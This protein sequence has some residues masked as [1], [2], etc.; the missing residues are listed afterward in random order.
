MKHIL[1]ASQQRLLERF[2]WSRVLIGL[3]FDGTLAPIVRIPDAAA[4]P[5][6]TRSVLEQLA[7]LYPTVVIS[8]RARQ[9]VAARL[10]GLRL[11]EIV[12]NHGLE[13]AARTR[14]K[15]RLVV[16]RWVHRLHRDLDAC[17]GV[18]IEDKGLSVAVHYRRSPS[19]PRALAA[20]T[21][22]VASLGRLRVLGGK[23]VLNLLP[24]GAPHKGRALQALQARAGCD[25][26]IFVGDDDTDED[27][28]GL[29]MGT[30]GGQ[31]SRLLGIRVGRQP[32]S[33]ASHFLRHRGEVDRLLRILRNLRGPAHG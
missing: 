12:G 29:R 17:A 24:E 32:G 8:G 7:T 25:H 5:P 23:L 16:A 3:D 6:R 26:A 31:P 33:Q 28:F 14:N 18:E 30:R 27:V 13:R 9:D 10:G 4:L 2:A 19:R 11:F 20:I 15:H 21:S 22:S 1:A